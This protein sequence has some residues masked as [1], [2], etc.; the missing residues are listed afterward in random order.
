MQM[1]KNLSTRSTP[2][3]VDNIIFG[4]KH[5]FSRGKDS[6]HR[7]YTIFNTDAKTFG[8]KDVGHWEGSFPHPKTD[9][10]SVL[11]MGT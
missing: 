5:P 8:S 6:F 4:Q 11:P 2:F 7:R 9:R 10:S 3:L 1:T